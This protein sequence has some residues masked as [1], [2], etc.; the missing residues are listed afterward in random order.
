MV[1]GTESFA[2]K[3]I[4]RSGINH[5]SNCMI[6]GLERDGYAIKMPP[7]NMLILKGD[8]LWIVGTR[9]SLGSIAAHSV[10]KAGSH[11]DGGLYE[12]KDGGEISR[13]EGEMK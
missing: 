12:R 3:P 1:R 8:I 2:G 6:L 9:S 13:S 10:G 4:R 11:E 7:S 5:R